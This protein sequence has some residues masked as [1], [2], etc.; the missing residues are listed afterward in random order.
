MLL[1][2]CVTVFPFSSFMIPSTLSLSCFLSSPSKGL[3]SWKTPLEKQLMI[4]SDLGSK[5]SYHSC[6]RKLPKDPQVGGL[7]GG[8]REMKKGGALQI[9][10]LEINRSEL[11]ALA[12]HILASQ[13]RFINR[14]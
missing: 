5:R 10:L 13:F 3:P 1:N 7:G 12:V 14:C 4:D 6:W 8:G 2:P 11:G 9:D